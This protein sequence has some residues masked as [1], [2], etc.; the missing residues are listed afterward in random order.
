MRCFDSSRCEVGE[1]RLP[2]LLAACGAVG[3]VSFSLLPIFFV[4]QGKLDFFLDGINA[5]YEDANPVTEAV[6]EAAGLAN[7]LAGAFVEQEA[8]AGQAVDGDEAFDEKVGQFD[9]EA[10]LGGTDDETVELI[11]D[12]FFHELNFLPVH[13]VAFG[14]VGA[15]LGVAAFGRDVL[16]IG[17]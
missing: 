14:V 3:A 13:E 1:S 15:A 17:L 9:E 12:T 6:G 7:D 5:V 8:V 4:N 11:A 2:L 10:E 16:Q